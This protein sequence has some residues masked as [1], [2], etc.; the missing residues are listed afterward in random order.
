[1][2]GAQQVHMRAVHNAAIGCCVRVR[3]HTIIGH[4]ICLII[5]TTCGC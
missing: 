1:M 3:V 4:W 2:K 5:V